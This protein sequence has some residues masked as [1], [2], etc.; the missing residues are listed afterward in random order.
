MGLTGD[1]MVPSSNRY[2]EPNIR[3]PSHSDARGFRVHRNGKG[4]FSCEYGTMWDL[5]DLIHHQCHYHI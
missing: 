5:I 3:V 2:H 4:E 1:I